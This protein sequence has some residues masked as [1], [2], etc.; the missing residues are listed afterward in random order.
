MARLTS[1]DL[2]SFLSSMDMRGESELTG[3]A[4]NT[5]AFFTSAVV[6]AGTVIWFSNHAFC[7]SGLAFSWLN[8][9]GKASPR[10]GS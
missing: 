10:Q 4:R 6:T 2:S 7:D 3:I 8:E 1:T 5:I 9:T